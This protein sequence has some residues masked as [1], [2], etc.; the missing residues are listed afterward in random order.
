MSE[1]DLDSD[2]L[3]DDLI[4]KPHYYKDLAF[5]TNNKLQH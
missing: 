3:G 1:D 2:N 4:V 5:S